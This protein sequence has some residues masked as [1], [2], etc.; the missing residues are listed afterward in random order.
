MKNL[1]RKKH[2]TSEAAVSLKPPNTVK[3]DHR[4]DWYEKPEGMG[5]AAG[6]W[7]QDKMGPVG[8]YAGKGLETAGKP[9]GG[10][11]DPL[12]GGLMRGSEAFGD[13]LGVGFGNK[14]GGPAK[15]KEAEGEKLKQ[16]VGGEEQTGDNP[17][18]LNHKS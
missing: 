14:E 8:Q 1:N 6:D 11:V 5:N 9:I 18:G 16:P 3:T 2:K 4:P 12:V 10:I 15:Q 7:I 13:N 17:L